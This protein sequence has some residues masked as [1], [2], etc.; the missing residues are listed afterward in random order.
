MSEDYKTDSQ[1]RFI[2]L[3]QSRGGGSI[4]KFYLEGLWQDLGLGV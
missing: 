3:N 1:P 4:S 2:C